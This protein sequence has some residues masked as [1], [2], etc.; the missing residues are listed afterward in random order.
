M[1]ENGPYRIKIDFE[2][3][4]RIVLKLGASCSETLIMDRIG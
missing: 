1:G 2:G 3:T 4:S